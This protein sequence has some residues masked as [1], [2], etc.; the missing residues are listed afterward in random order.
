MKSDTESYNGIDGGI[1]AVHK[2]VPFLTIY[3]RVND[4]QAYLDKA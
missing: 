3:V 1:L 2:G 4:I